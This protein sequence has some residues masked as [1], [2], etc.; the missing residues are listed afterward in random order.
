[1]PTMVQIDEDIMKPLRELSEDLNGLPI[2]RLVRVACVAYLNNHHLSHEA[3]RKLLKHMT[4]VEPLGQENK[5]STEP[6]EGLRTIA[7]LL[8]EQMDEMGLSEEEKNRKVDT[9]V[10][11]VKKLKSSRAGSR[12]K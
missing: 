1:M 11:H 7:R 12:P 3:A 9:L 4:P 2:T 6:A 5:K 10:E 8:E